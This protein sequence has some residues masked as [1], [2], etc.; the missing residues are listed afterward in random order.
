MKKNLMIFNPSLEDGGV[1]KNFFIIANFF[2]KKLDNV[3]VLT[4]SK[5]YKYKFNKNISFIS[6]KYFFWDNFG[7]II[8]YIISLYLLFI[9]YLK[10]KDLTVF[11]FQGN[12]LC[13]IFVKSLV[14][15]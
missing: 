4:I 14:L 7:R 11:C 13:I 5:K 10:N 8:K 12:V 6:T 1:E 9:E 15:K 3:S 2:T